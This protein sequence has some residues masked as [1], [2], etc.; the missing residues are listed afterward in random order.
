MYV[1]FQLFAFVKLAGSN[2]QN[3]IG[4][5]QFSIYFVSLIKIL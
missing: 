2:K 3:Q 4:S 5:M 1:I